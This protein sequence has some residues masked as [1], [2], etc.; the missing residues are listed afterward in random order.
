M[1]SYTGCWC[2]I[3]INSDKFDKFIGNFVRILEF[4]AVLWFALAF[5]F[6]WYI[7]CIFF[8]KRV[9][10]REV[11]KSLLI[12]LFSY[13]LVLVFCWSWTTINRI[14]NIFGENSSALNILQIV[15]VSFE[16]LFNA[17]CYGLNKNV[18]SCLREK[19]CGKKDTNEM[20][21][22]NDFNEEIE[23]SE[24]LND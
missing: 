22:N 1:Y 20:N 13:P 17:I 4:E 3:A 19:L 14:Y 15:F 7:R 21:E 6:Y 23:M 18:R 11:N 2:W 24:N 10:K 16:G 8:L 9:Y 12:R 5:N